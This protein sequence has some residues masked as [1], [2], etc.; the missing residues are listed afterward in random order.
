MLTPQK[1]SCNLPAS[2]WSLPNAK[3]ISALRYINMVTIE[4]LIPNAVEDVSNKNSF[5]L[6]F[7]SLSWG[8]D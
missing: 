5:A 8:N 7:W 4:S 3:I 1:L 6:F 2:G